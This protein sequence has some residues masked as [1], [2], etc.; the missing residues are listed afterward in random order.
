[1]TSTRA[2]DD[3][4]AAV[5]ERLT[6]AV[7]SLTSGED[8]AR[9]L[10]TAARF[11]RYSA[12]NSLLIQLQAPDA[13]RVAGYRTWTALGRQVRRGERGIA[14]LAP[15]L[16]RARRELGGPD[17][18]EGAQEEP[19]AATLR[20][21]RVAY[22]FDIASTEGKPLP[23]VA[24]V[25]IEGEAPGALWDR[26]AQQVA[27][28]GYGLARG[29]CAPANGRTD[30]VARTV[31]VAGHLPPAQAAKT[32]AH[33]LA[34]VVL[35]EPQTEQACRGRVEV[36]A[37]SVAYVVCAVAGLDT[38]TYSFPYVARWSAGDAE[39]V[40]RC[41]ERAVG[42]AR[43]IVAAAGLAPAEPDPANRSV[44]ARDVGPEPGAKRRSWG[45]AIAPPAP[46]REGL[47]R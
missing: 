25:L 46:D 10:A 45:L 14:I 22:V 23:E 47:T 1:M 33:E 37:E 19:T 42:A 18:R 40:R 27:A 29:D 16:A 31:T 34:H 6:E 15:V 13:T 39:V 12:A 17:G 11:H 7:A 43:R 5:H 9:M 35:H 20:G 41:A 24:P 36:E 21:F 30:F 26:L 8:W 32:L 28:S 4:L 2:P 38:G 44:L 3:R